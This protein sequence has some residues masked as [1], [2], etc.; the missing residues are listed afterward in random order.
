MGTP[1]EKR[2]TAPTPPPPDQPRAPRTH[3]QGT[4][5]KNAVVAHRE[6]RTPL[7]SFDISL[8]KMKMFV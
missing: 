8:R 4:A 6:E 2:E 3:Q 1:G 5:P 7:L